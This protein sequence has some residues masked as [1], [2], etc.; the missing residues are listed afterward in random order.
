M[1]C[2]N[3]AAVSILFIQKV[4]FGGSATTNI[5]RHSQ[6]MKNYKT[7]L[8]ER[9]T[10]FFFFEIWC[11]GVAL[12]STCPA[13]IEGHVRNTARQSLYQPYV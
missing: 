10:F 9:R 4:N 6:K 5:F 7:W 13:W 1:L 2:I 11:F 3:T 12:I 8:F